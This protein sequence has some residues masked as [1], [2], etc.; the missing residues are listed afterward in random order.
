MKRIYFICLVCVLAI[1]GCE[2]KHTTN[3]STYGYVQTA[4]GL[5]LQGI[6]V[7]T[8]VAGLVGVDTVYSNEE[9]M[10]F[11]RI[12]KIP[13]PIPSVTVT[14]LDPN[15]IYRTQSIS[16]HYMYECG[17]GFVPEN[18]CAFPSEEITFVLSK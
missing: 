5:A 18:D 7:I 15:G 14:A 6:A 12:N 10:F 2:K 13:Y 11:S 16:P 8:E 4:E 17:T 9:G 1:A 3:L